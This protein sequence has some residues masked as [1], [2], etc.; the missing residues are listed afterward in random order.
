MS[1][2]TTLLAVSFLMISST[3]SAKPMEFIKLSWNM[4]I[5]SMVKSLQDRGYACHVQATKNLLC[6]RADVSPM[7]Q[8]WLYDDKVR[9]SCSN[10]KGCDGS[11]DSMAQ[12]VA[13]KYKI[14]LTEGVKEIG[15]LSLKEI[16]GEGA[17]GDK[18]CITESPPYNHAVTLYRHKIPAP[19]RSAEF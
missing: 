15:A 9:F 11:I 12:S 2:V 18:I 17:S 16:C 7:A 8:V 19:E 4:S 5:E 13:N 3:V 14:R 6:T 10:Y 1:R